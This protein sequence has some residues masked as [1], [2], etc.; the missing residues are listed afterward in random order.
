MLFAGGVA[1]FADASEEHTYLIMPFENVA[2][3]PSLTWLST[4]LALSL[5]EYLRGAGVHVVDDEIRAIVLEAHGIPAGADLTLASVLQLG[6]IMR[7]RPNIPNPDHTLVGT[8][9][10]TDGELTLRARWIH[11]NREYADPWI[12]QEGR[13][14]DLLKIHARLAKDVA[15]QIEL[16]AS[17]RHE[18]R[19]G[20][21]AFGDPP[22]LAF[23]SYC[24]GMAETDPE[25]RLK[26]LRQAVGEFPDYYRAAYQTAAVLAKT[27]RWND[28]VIMLDK[29][30]ADPH[31]YR[32]DY[33]LLEATIALE[34][35]RPEDAAEAAAKAFKV[36]ETADA[37]ILLCKARLASGD[38][39]GARSA[40]DRAITI[41]P[42]DPEIDDLRAALSPAGSGGTTR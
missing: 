22:L 9:N 3:D 12:E 25:K 24:R 34:Q 16:P 28:A 19:S 32:Y 14:S 10:I 13:L 1:A 39:E 23:E 11:L 40:L 2:E 20:A 38:K 4:G 37:Q 36:R 8:F 26:L 33:F 5:G 30:E 15:K 17:H 7:S 31:P 21:D 41:D 42:D 35:R 29:A 27:D 6:R 18:Q